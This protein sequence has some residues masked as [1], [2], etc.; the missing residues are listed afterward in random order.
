M[1]PRR[2]K[3]PCSTPGCPELVEA[4]QRFCPE[5]LRQERRDRD[6]DHDRTRPSA[7]K[8][9]YD[10]HWQRLRVMVLRRQVFCACGCGKVSEEVH[11]KDGDSSN[12]SWDNLEA[13]SK[14]CHSKLTAK[15][16]GWGR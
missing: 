6:R 9:G 8:R 10:R 4:G 11:H 15:E 5:H 16:K 1:S 13:L 2:P 14:V 3:K 7:A 12:N